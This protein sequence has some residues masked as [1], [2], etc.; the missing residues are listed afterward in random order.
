MYLE[1]YSVYYKLTAKNKLDIKIISI[2]GAIL[3]K[4]INKF[5]STNFGCVF[6]QQDIYN[7]HMDIY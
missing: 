6:I 4:I 7:T 1:I 2:A 5:Q 3:G